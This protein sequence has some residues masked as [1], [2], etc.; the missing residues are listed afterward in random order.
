MNTNN[1]TPTQIQLLATFGPLIGWLAGYIGA[2]NGIDQGT[3]LGILTAII[4]GGLSIYN[5]W[6]S[7]K[8]AQVSA[9]A[10]MPEVSNVVL[11]KDVPNAKA[12][13]EATPNNVTVQ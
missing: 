13:E 10:N 8:S 9:V 11:D 7:R 12:I 2:W 5:M 4:V 3:M 6:I 1:L